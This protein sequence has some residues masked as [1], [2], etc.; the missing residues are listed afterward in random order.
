MLAFTLIAASVSLLLTDFK[1]VIQTHVLERYQI[2]LHLGRVVIAVC[3]LFF[4]SLRAKIFI[5]I[6]YMMGFLYDDQQCSLR[7]WLLFSYQ[8][9]N[10]NTSNNHDN[11]N[12]S[13]YYSMVQNLVHY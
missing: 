10:N 6:L 3:L 11:G 12:E 4:V 13:G 8:F 2:G 9:S 5:T 1:N 7:R